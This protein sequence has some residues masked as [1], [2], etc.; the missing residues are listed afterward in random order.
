VEYLRAFTDARYWRAFWNAAI[1]QPWALLFVVLFDVPGMSLVAYFRLVRR[2]ESLLV[3]ALVLT[4]AFFYKVGADAWGEAY[5]DKVHLE[6]R[7]KPRL[8]FV[9]DPHR[10]PA[11]IQ[12]TRGEDGTVF[13]RMYRVALVNLSDGATVDDVE[14]LLAAL[15]GLDGGKRTKHV[16]SLPARLVRMGDHGGMVSPFHLN[17]GPTPVFLDVAGKASTGT[18]VENISLQ[19]GGHLPEDLEPGRYKLRVVAK[20]R[21]A[22]EVEV[23]L[24]MSVDASGVLIVEQASASRPV[25]SIN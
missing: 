14:V 2:Q 25:S 15:E 16:A 17:P 9:L 11:C 13:W 20:S 22:V 7:L 24:N 8:E 6:E 10:Y 1:K 4:A 19:C 21:N 23:L 3:V 5:R 12:E 18:R